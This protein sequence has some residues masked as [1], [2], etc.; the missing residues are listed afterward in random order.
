MPEV[1]VLA[2]RKARLPNRAPGRTMLSETARTAVYQ[3]RFVGAWGDSARSGPEKKKSASIA[4]TVVS[5]VGA[6]Q[7]ALTPP[8][9]IQQAAKLR[10]EDPPGLEGVQRL[11]GSS[12][13]RPR[14]SAKFSA[15]TC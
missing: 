2:V 13:G 4:T 9:P 14:F 8:E 12:A 11:D 6:E 3:N 10:R 5:P 15:R 1:A 7:V